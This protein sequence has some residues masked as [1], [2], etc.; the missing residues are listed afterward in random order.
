[1]RK[2]GKRAAA[3]GMIL[4]MLLPVLGGCG[5]KGGIRFTAGLKDTELFRLEEEICERPE[6]MIFMLSQ[7]TKYEHEYGSGIWEVM[8]GD[9]TFGEYMRD[10]LQ[11]FLAKM[12]CMVLMAEKYEVVLTDEEN[13]RISQ[14]AETYVNGL[15]DQVRKATSIDK[16]AAETVFHDY[17]ISN[18]LMEKL[19]ADVSTEISED[20]ARVIRVQQIFLG[21]EGLSG[22][23]KEVKRTEA[24]NIRTQAEAGA[25]FSALGKNE[26][27]A[28]EF[29]LELCRGE[30]E[31]QFEEAAFALSSG[32]ISEVVETAYGF[33]VIKC[34]NNYDEAKTAE[35]KEALVRKHKEDRFYEYYDAFV[36]TIVAEYNEKAWKRLDYREDFGTP[37]SDFYEVYYQY[38]NDGQ[39]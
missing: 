33:H 10:N 17:Y 39:Q 35:N 1:M 32:Q 36:K 19:T 6:A 3:L 27:E 2:I 30:A 26:N 21:T 31:P 12:K 16:T 38:F 20:E 8:I 28:E 15:S 11:D 9:K 13:V 23:E 22:T 5:K 7:K 37:G 14:A 18:R 4:C 25:D 34:I 24:Q 29:E